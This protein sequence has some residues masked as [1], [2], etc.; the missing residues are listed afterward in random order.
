MFTTKYKP[1]DIE[2]F[3]GNKNAIK[4]LSSWLINWKPTNV[5]KCSLLH[6]TNGI[7]KSLLTELLL[8]KLGYDVI[9]SSND[10]ERNYEYFQTMKPLINTYSYERKYVIVFHDIDASNDHKFICNL[11]EFILDSKIPIICICDNKYDLSIKPLLSISFDVFLQTPTNSEIYD[12]VKQIVTKEKVNIIVGSLKNMIE[13]ANGDIRFVL[14]HLQLGVFT[15]IKDYACDNIFKTTKE[16]FSIVHNFDTKFNVFWLFNDMHPLMIHENYIKNVF[17]NG[18]VLNNLCY[19]SN[20]LSDYDILNKFIHVNSNWELN[21]Y[22]ACSAIRAT[23]NCH[24]NYAQFTQL[25]G[26][27]SIINANRMN[28]LCE[29]FNQTLYV[30]HDKEKVIKEKVVKEKV[31]KEK[32]VKEKVVKEKVVKE[33]VVKEK[34]VKEK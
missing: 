13:N 7:G 28:G 1:I 22:T 11:M 3:V 14:N 12:F 16:L 5:E 17:I 30:L 19:S 34:V 25:L 23:T 18:N 2:Q 31:V 27:T 6:G 26:K 9:C 8:K 15:G 33:K 32:V 20:A 29:K 24:N 10:D 4:L 21:D